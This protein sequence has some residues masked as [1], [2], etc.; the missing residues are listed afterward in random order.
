MV[1]CATRDLERDLN[2]SRRFLDQIW[3]IRTFF[4]VVLAEEMEG[5]NVAGMYYLLR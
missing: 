2:F 5:T 3:K 4:F 1:G